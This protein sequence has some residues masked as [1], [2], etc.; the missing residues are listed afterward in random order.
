MKKIGM[1]FMVLACVAFLTGPV[2]AADNPRPAASQLVK[3]F[4]QRNGQSLPQRTY[5]Y[6]VDLVTNSSS[7][8]YSTV[9]ALTN[10]D[11]ISRIRIQGFVVPK[12]AYPG[13]EKA[14]DFWLNPY[15]VSYL[16]LSQ[17]LVWGSHHEHHERHGADL[18]YAVVLVVRLGRE[19]WLSL[20]LGPYQ[21][22]LLNRP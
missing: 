18:G 22:K 19:H 1:F 17:Y 10:Y 15:E 7:A 6:L 11:A 16:P 4:A 2:W 12:G 3:D 21:L 14:V 20:S 13:G 8:G 9:F 5:V